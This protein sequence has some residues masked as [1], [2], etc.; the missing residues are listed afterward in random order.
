LGTAAAQIAYSLVLVWDGDLT[1]AEPLLESAH[2]MTQAPALPVGMRSEDVA[3]IRDYG[4]IQRANLAWHQ[5]DAD[6]G[7]QLLREVVHETSLPRFRWSYLQLLAHARSQQG[8]AAGA[9]EVDCEAFD[10]ALQLGEEEMVLVA[11]ENIACDLRRLG[12]L[13]DAEAQMR[14]VIPRRLS[15]GNPDANITVAEDLGAIP[16]EQGRCREAATLWGAAMA[17]RERRHF[18]R[19]ATTEQELGGAVEVARAALGETWDHWLERGH[20]LTVDQALRQTL[21]G[22]P[23]SV[24]GR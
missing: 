16:S 9:H 24:A 6:R 5:G 18:P 10:L 3:L 11:G 1:T 8:D 13:D 21:T 12:R 7:E 22:D 15:W 23:E 20:V 17:E 2:E 4:D 14:W 19:R